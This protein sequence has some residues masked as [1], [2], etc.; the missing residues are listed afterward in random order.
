M[1]SSALTRDQVEFDIGCIQEFDKFT[2][3]HF[4]PIRKQYFL[5][6]LYKILQIVE[7]VGRRSLR[8]LTRART[9]QPPSLLMTCIFL[10]LKDYGC[11]KKLRIL[12]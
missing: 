8:A 4:P 11:L 7:G 6:N 1:A 12:G 10:K 2:N 5:E 3:L 9:R